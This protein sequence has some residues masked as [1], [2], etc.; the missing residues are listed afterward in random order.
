MYFWKNYELTQRI[1]H[2][3]MEACKHGPACV[4]Q[5]GGGGGGE[6]EERGVVL[7]A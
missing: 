3:L 6:G 1:I 7:E 2:S 5:E 4:V